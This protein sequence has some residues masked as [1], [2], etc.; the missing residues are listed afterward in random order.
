MLQ[1]AFLLPIINC[2]IE[3]KAELIVDSSHVEPQVIIVSP[4]RELA[5]QIHEEAR[6]FAYDTGLKCV[7]AYGG[8][9]VGYQ[10][11]QLMVIIVSIPYTS[12]TNLIF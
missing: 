8:T 9:S 11:K 5:I 3:D 1:A 2:L 4:T 12:C 6:K 7:I 10:I